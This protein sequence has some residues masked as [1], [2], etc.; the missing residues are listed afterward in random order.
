MK[1]SQNDPKWKKVKMGISNY[2][3]G[4]WGCTTSS[5]CTLGSYFGENKTPEDL[6]KF[7]PLYTKD[8]FIIWKQLENILEKLKFR[9]RYYSFNEDLIDE[10]LIA[11]PNTCVLLNVNRNYHWVAALRKVN[12]GYLCS[13]PWNYPAKNR[14]YK[15]SEIGGFAVLIKK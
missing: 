6:A 2:R 11:N 13:D 4:G 14:T 9:Y 7:K 12:G 10:Y 8:G 3:L 5:V 1:Y 15:N